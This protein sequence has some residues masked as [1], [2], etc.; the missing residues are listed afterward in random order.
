MKKEGIERSGEQ[1]NAGGTKEDNGQAKMM[2]EFYAVF[3]EPNK[4]I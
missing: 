3:G 2:H 4:E 1:V